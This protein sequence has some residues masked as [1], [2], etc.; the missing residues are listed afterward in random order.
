MITGS[1]SVATFAA[2]EQT[3]FTASRATRPRR[4]LPRSCSWRRAPPSWL[5]CSW[6]AWAASPP[7]RCWRRRAQL[8][9]CSTAAWTP[10]ACLRCW[11]L[12]PSW[13]SSSGSAA[14]TRAPR[15]RRRW[16]A[17]RTSWRVLRLSWWTASASTT[18]PLRCTARPLQARRPRSRS[19]SHHYRL[20]PALC[21]SGA[22]LLL[23]R[24]ARR[25]P[26][27]L[28]RARLLRQRRLLHR[29]PL[30]H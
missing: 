20:P 26:R 15:K 23:P 16:R 5:R 18:T 13:H 21:C 6:A 19:R 25:L 3:Q 1:Y 27:L 7:C 28:R 24:Q 11:C 8:M 17:R 10:A 29:G 22:R 4:C 14:A 30:L 2:L 9:A 12:Y